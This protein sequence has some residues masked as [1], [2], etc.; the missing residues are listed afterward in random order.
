MTPTPETM[1]QA[2]LDYVHTVHQAYLSQADLQAPAIRGRMSLLGKP[3][4]VVAVGVQ[5]LHVIATREPLPAPRGQEVEVGDNLAD[6]DWTVRFYDPVVLPALGMI[7]ES[8]GPAG[9]HPPLPPDRSTRE[10][11]DRSPR[12]PRRSGTGQL[13]HRR[14]PRF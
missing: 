1:R 6:L 14:S 12:R 13:P 11:V 2:M 7:D 10:P 8:A 9:D 5:N 4:T 3:F